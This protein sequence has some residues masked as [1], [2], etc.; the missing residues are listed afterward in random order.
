MVTPMLSRRSLCNDLLVAGG[1]IE[2]DKMTRLTF[3]DCRD[4]SMK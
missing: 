3:R 2:G 1:V 4:H